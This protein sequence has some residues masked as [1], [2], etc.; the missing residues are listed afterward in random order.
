[1]GIEALPFGGMS[2][3]EKVELE[4][5]NS[6]IIPPGAEA[7]VP[8]RWR[9]H[10]TWQRPCGLVKLLVGQSTPDLVVGRTRVNTDGACRARQSN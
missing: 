2:R 9:A 6:V 4:A 8:A 5:P 10:L 1:M 7:I 3:D